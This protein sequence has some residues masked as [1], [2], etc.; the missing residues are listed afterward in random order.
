MAEFMH[1][2]EHIEKLEIY[3]GMESF[4]TLSPLEARVI[5]TRLPKV[6]DFMYM[7]E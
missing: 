5:Y 1:R 3:T 6:L 7:G 4:T 2:L